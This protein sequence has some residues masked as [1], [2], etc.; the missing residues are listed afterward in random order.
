LSL[1]KSKDVPKWAKMTV[2][3]GQKITYHADESKKET[4]EFLKFI[5]LKSIPRYI[6]ID[7][8]VEVLDKD[9]IHP[10]DPR[11]LLRLRNAIKPKD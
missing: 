5:E 1:D 10:Q 6:L 8:D 4:K 2:D 11:F 3:L 9:I 7:K